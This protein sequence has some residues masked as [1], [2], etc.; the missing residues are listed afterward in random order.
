MNNETL[1]EGVLKALR[2][3][4][5]YSRLVSDSERLNVYE[6][7]AFYVKDNIKGQYLQHQA[8]MYIIDRAHR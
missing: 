7:A 4:A 5:Q 3:L 8:M 2:G 1:E 6:A